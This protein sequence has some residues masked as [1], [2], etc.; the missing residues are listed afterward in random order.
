MEP[1]CQKLEKMR[2][3]MRLQVLDPA[4]MGLQALDSALVCNGQVRPRVVL[5]GNDNHECS[6]SAFVFSGKIERVCW[7]YVRVCWQYVPYD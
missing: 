4:K 3:K 2:M 1:K 5:H 7:Q 6:N